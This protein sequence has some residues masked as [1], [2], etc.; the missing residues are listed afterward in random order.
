MD[1]LQ[2]H[3]DCLCNACCMT[4]SLIEFCHSTSVIPSA[5]LINRKINLDY[6]S[7]LKIEAVCSSD[8]SVNFYHTILCRSSDTT[9]LHEYSVCKTCVLTRQNKS[10]QSNLL[11]KGSRFGRMLS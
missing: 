8:T 1:T 11:S 3:A 6:Y 5:N 4:S 7:I 9:T 2:F 10:N